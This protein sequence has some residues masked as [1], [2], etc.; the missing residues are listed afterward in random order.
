[1]EALVESTDGFFLAERDLEIRGEGT[2]F[3]S[4]QSGASDLKIASLKNMSMLKTAAKDAKELLEADSR[5][6]DSPL[7]KE[8]IF[9]IYEKK[10]IDS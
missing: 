1:M 6:L 4:Q 10:T 9:T 2:L 3:S 7:L 8:E 5:L